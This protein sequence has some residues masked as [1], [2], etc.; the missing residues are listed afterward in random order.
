MTD[1]LRDPQS[2]SSFKQAGF[3]VGLKQNPPHRAAGQF[4][5]VRLAGFIPCTK[6]QAQP[7]ALAGEV[8]I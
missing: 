6:V 8:G 3:I 2:V 7:L 4:L 1:V 5:S